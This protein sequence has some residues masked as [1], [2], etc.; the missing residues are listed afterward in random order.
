[1]TVISTAKTA[2]HPAV[3]AHVALPAENVR[4]RTNREV[5]WCAAGSPIGDAA[6]YS[7]LRDDSDVVVFCFT[8][9]EDAEAL[10]ER[11]GRI[12]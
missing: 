7:M 4:Y 11:F 9:P 12:G 6:P 8:E 1:M 2:D 5:I 3:H 10:A